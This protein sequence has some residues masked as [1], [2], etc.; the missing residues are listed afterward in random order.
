MR[1]IT[2]N[3][4][5]IFT[6]DLPEEVNL[7]RT[8]ETVGAILNGSFL[9]CACPACGAILHTDLETR[10]LWPS[11]GMRLIMVPELMRF[12]IISSRMAVPEGFAI[13]IG[14]VE[15]SDRVSVYRDDLDPMTVETL[16]FHLIRKAMETVQGKKLIATYERTDEESNLEF[17]LHGLRDAEVAVMKVPGKL[18]NTVHAG[19]KAH[20]DE[21]PQTLLLN[22]AYLSVQNLVFEEM[23]HD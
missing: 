1:K 23:D 12:S 15:L 16:K 4:E 14:Y 21:E 17:H 22:G 2:C 19:I 13:V 8:P 11:K 20:P 5:Q 10:V 9:T 18:Y 6:A 3:C 7:D